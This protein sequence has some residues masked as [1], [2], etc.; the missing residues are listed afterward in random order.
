MAKSPA[1]AQLPQPRDV[2]LGHAAAYLEKAQPCLHAEGSLT[3]L[4][5]EPGF[6][7]LPPGD[8][9]DSN[10]DPRLL[11]P[12]RKIRW[13]RGAQQPGSQVILAQ[14]SSWLD[15]RAIFKC[16]LLS[17]CDLR[18]TIF[19]LDIRFCVILTGVTTDDLKLSLAHFKDKG[20]EA[21]DVKS[22]GQDHTAVLEERLSW[23]TALLLRAKSCPRIVQCSHTVRCH[24]NRWGD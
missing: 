4:C 8:G 10:A 15:H 21:E 24:F 1:P 16:D 20:M 18:G 22:L 2:S 23:Q 13:V 6:S 5:D 9:C 11:C 14:S 7:N 17:T 12:E 19:F 3:L